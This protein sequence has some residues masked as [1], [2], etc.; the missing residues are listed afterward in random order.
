[1]VG[2]E[3]YFRSVGNNTKGFRKGYRVLQEDV[4]RLEYELSRIPALMTQVPR[5]AQLA[6]EATGRDLAQEQQA[7]GVRYIPIEIEAAPADEAQ[8]GRQSKELNSSEAPDYGQIAVSNVYRTAF[9]LFETNFMGSTLTARLRLEAPNVASVHLFQQPQAD[10]AT[11][12]ETGSAERAEALPA[13]AL[14]LFI[15]TQQVRDLCAALAK[16]SEWTRSAHDHSIG[17]GVYTEIR[18]PGE[19]KIVF[20]T[21]DQLLL[22]NVVALANYANLPG[23]PLAERYEQTK[24]FREVV[25]GREE[26]QCLSAVLPGL[27]ELETTVSEKLKALKEDQEKAKEFLK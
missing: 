17:A 7:P 11:K 4:N 23:R 24:T 20:V 10:Q 18:S 15:A 26:T 8:A 25:L 16:Y 6:P 2:A 3:E 12:P 9:K 22:Q 5:P 21:P 19:M 1:M 14:V 13:K 27:T